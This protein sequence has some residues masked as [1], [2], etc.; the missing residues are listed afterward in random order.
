MGVLVYNGGTTYI[1]ISASLMKLIYNIY[2]I[3]R[4]RRRY[5]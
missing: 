5:A 2:F 4:M 1:Q 3:N